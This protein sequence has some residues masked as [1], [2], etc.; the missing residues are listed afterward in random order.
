[1]VRP[2]YG[3]VAR[4][5]AIARGRR[6]APQATTQGRGGWTRA[7]RM[8]GRIEAPADVPRAPRRGVPGGCDAPQPRGAS[9]FV[10]LPVPLSC[11]CPLVLPCACLPA[12][13][14]SSC[15]S[16]PVRQPSQWSCALVWQP[17]Q[18]FCA[19][20]WQPLQWFCA[21]VWQPSQWS[22][23]LVWQPSQSS[24]LARLVLTPS[25]WSC[26]VRLVPVPS[27]CVC[28]RGLVTWV[29]PPRFR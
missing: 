2:A 9:H 27:S 26:V 23:A 6:S 12:P 14:L 15:V 22:C 13:T 5:P 4:A 1:M 29:R 11:A 21:L 3:H 25:Q 20:V 24:C 18:W 8:R 10:R 16:G 19:L 28:V 17:S 7:P